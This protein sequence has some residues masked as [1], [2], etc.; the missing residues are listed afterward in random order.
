MALISVCIPKGA[1]LIKRQRFIRRNTVFNIFANL[2]ACKY[3][4]YELYHGCFSR[5]FLKFFKTAFSKNKAGRILLIPS[6]YSLKIPRTPSIQKWVKKIWIGI[7]CTNVD[8]KIKTKVKVALRWIIRLWNR[9]LKVLKF[10]L[11]VVESSTQ[12]WL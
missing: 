3:V 6:D 5:N 12:D 8:R 4:E 9:F 2:K 11:N 7:S 1:A 10:W